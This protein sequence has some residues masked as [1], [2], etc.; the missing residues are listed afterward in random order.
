MLGAL[1]EGFVD[2]LSHQDPAKGCGAAG[3]P[4]GKGNHVGD[5]AVALSGEG[6]AE[7]PEAGDHLV[8][9]EEDAVG[10][11]DLAQALKIA[12]RACENAG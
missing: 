8:E 3:H 10:A 5:D 1:H 6:V 12:L 2:M 7:P 11:G 9:D 4:L